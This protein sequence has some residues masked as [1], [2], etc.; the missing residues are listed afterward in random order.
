MPPPSWACL[1]VRVFAAKGKDVP[2]ADARKQ[3]HRG[4]AG[5]QRN[6]PERREYLSKPE[7]DQE[8]KFGD[9]E[10][11]L[12]LSMG[13]KARGSARTLTREIPY[14][15]STTRTRRKVRALRGERSL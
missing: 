2:L 13:L 1:Y 12:A 5:M 7:N 14:R 6:T 9:A 8:A 10:Q 15:G 4:I 3:R 11:V